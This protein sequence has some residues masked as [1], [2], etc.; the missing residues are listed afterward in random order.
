M[1]DATDRREQ[2]RQWIS[3][4]SILIDLQDGRGPITCRIW[5]ISAIGARILVPPDVALPHSFRIHL[6]NE[7]QIAHVIW[8]RDWHAGIR[9]V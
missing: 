9:F 3:D 4:E 5:D 8:R 6:K 2:P 7:W 1:H